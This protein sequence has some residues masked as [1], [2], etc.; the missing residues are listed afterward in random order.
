MHCRPYFHPV[1]PDLV[2]TLTL[3]QTFPAPL[4]PVLVSLTFS[5]CAISLCRSHLL[6]QMT[7]AVLVPRPNGPLYPSTIFLLAVQLLCFLKSVVHSSET[8]LLQAAPSCMYSYLSCICTWMNL[9]LERWFLWLRL[10]FMICWYRAVSLLGCVVMGLTW[11]LS[12]WIIAN[13]SLKHSSLPAIFTQFSQSFW[14][15]PPVSEVSDMSFREPRLTWLSHKPP[16]GRRRIQ[17][18]ILSL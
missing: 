9:V 10:C 4:N 13:I 16:G 6:H 7:P 12:V 2:T 14:E 1:L 11:G 15:G 3:S 18:R 5:F 17:I 8:P